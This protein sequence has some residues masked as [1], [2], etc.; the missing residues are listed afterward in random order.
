MDRSVQFTFLTVFLLFTGIFV[1]KTCQAPPRPPINIEGPA[2]GLVNKELT[3]KITNL[4]DED[5]DI[6][7]S[8][9]E[10]G[11]ID[12]REASPVIKYSKAGTY[13][14]TLNVKNHPPLSSQVRIDNP[15]L[16]P[17]II[18]GPAV[19]MVRK[20]IT[21]SLRN[22]KPEDTNI[23][24][25]FGESG[26]IDSRIPTPKYKYQKAGTYLITVHIPDHPDTKMTIKINDAARPVTAPASKSCTNISQS[27]LQS[28]FQQLVNASSDDRKAQIKNQLLSY[29]ANPMDE[30]VISDSHYPGPRS[31]NAMIRT[32]ESITAKSIRITGMEKSPGN[33]IT[34][35]QISY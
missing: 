9:G 2:D 29:F 14:I 27:E 12:S 24:W 20:E 31:L 32:S 15:P 13:K 23:E 6:E 8:F 26:L 33:C 18:D 10:S 25:S 7:W 21:F 17:I 11:K 4:S 3:F 35:L 1:Y 22:L 5:K 28:L 19:E 30:S 34:Y 16:T